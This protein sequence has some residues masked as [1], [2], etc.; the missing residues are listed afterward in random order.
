[1]PEIDV[2]ALKEQVFGNN[3]HS[4]TQPQSQDKTKDEP[5]ATTAPNNIV[6]PTQTVVT[7]PTTP[8]APTTQV[9]NKD[10]EEAVDANEYLKQNLGFDSWE[11]AKT[12]IEALRQKAQTPAEIKYANEQSR[13]LYESIL[14]GET[15]KVYDILDTQRKIDGLDKMSAPEV[16]KLHIAQQHKEYK[17]VDIED[18][19]DEKYTYPEKPTKL[20]TDLE[21]EYEARV[22]KWKVAKEKIDRRI[23]RD[24]ATAK[25]E[26]SKIKSELK[27]PEIQK[28]IQPSDEAAKTLIKE[29][30]IIAEMQ[31]ADK[32]AYSKITP[33][34]VAMVFK[35]NDEASKL[36]FDI[37]Y[38]PEKESFE[39]AVAEASDLTKFFE[40]YYGK[41]GSPDRVK[42]LREI[43]AGRN[44]EKIVTEAVVLATNETK[45]WF[46]A[47]QKNI[48]D[49]TQRNFTVQQPSEIDKLKEQVFGKTG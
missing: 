40:N 2:T 39:K 37:A 38:E 31:K 24:A 43:Y 4:S 29:Q 23:E 14:A 15:N 48:G 11:V 7:T 12:E 34:D 47:N 3:G 10:D 30:E 49:R 41:D 6:E 26:L 33:K 25:Q 42:L 17:G 44:I 22:D 45:K 13:Q 20:D 1:M 18:V 9:V 5:P 21:G 19:F 46:L 36:A 8:V 32:E 27:L 16:I 28:S 35:F